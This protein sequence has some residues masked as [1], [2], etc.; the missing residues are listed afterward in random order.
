[1]SQGVKACVCDTTQT[2][3]SFCWSVV[4]VAV[5]FDGREKS[6]PRVPSHASV[7]VDNV[8]TVV[9]IGSW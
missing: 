4:T 8:V 5:S 2:K 3:A 1:M 9:R 6:E 7:R